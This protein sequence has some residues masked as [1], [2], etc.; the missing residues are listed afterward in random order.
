VVSSDATIAVPDGGTGGSL[1]LNFPAGGANT[2]TFRVRGLKVGGAQFNVEGDIASPTPLSVAV[3]TGPASLLTENFG[4]AVDTAKWQV[5]NRSFEVGTGTYTV[6]Q[7]TGTLEISGATETDFWAGASLKTVNSYVA[8]KDLNLVFEV[9]R[10]SIDQAGSAGRTGVFITTGD[11]SKFVFFSHNMGENGWQVNVNPGSPTGN[12]AG[13]AAFAGANDTANHRIK[14]VADGSTVEVF[15]DGVSGGK[16]AFEVTSGIFFEVGAYARA[17]GDTIIGVFDNVR[18]D[19]TLPCVSADASTVVLTQ[20]DAPKTVN[21]TIPQ[22]LNDTAPV[23]VTVTSSNPA[24]A[25][26]TGAVNGVLK[27]DFAAGAANSQSITIVPAGLG[28]ATFSITTD[29]PVCV[30]DSIKVEVVAVPQ[31]QLADDFTAGSVNA[32]NWRED[33]TPFDT[34]TA[35]ADSAI[36][37]ANGQVKFSVTAETASWPG[38]ALYTVKT[39]TA[40]A[41]APTTFEI[42]RVLLDFDLVTGTGARQRAGVWVREPNG[43]FV[44]FAENSAHD[45]NNF[46]W[47]YNLMIGQA[48]DNP[49]GDGVN[50]G[51]FDG[52]KFDDQ[53]NHRIKVVVNGAT[54][55]LFLDGVL[56][57]EVPFPYASGL[58]FGFGAYVSAATDVVRGYF[59]N[60]KVSGGSAPVAGRFNPVSVQGANVVISWTGGG[61]LQ[62]TAALGS[63]WTDVTP[64]PTGNSVTVSA[65]AANTRFYRLR[66]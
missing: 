5:N 39:F 54:A 20:A 29:P 36:T 15:L 66:P 52:G 4:A 62:S 26:A 14:L 13:I 30:T 63:A 12:P 44:F 3:I 35:T 64:A 41:T 18:I 22:L 59:D 31:V 9:D 51:A 11:R 55:K 58:S 27:L 1:T 16:F 37:I 17:T 33:T 61:V 34:G 7:K 28:A 23:T 40:S 60:A 43:N 6:L 45:G 48:N 46:G 42:D 8:T 19:N 24:A 32:T 38:L 50:I 49:I 47:R 56:G 57:A 10:V 53:K 21:I 25:T 65:G 2:A